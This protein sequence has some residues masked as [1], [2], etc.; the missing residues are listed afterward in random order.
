MIFKVALL[1]YLTDKRY[2]YDINGLRKTKKYGNTTYKYYYSGDKLLVEDTNNYSNR[3][4]YDEKGQLYGFIQNGNKYFYVRDIM[5]NILG[6]SSQSGELVVK[7]NYDAYGKL[8]ST[9]GTLAS[10]VGVQNPFLYKG[11]I[12]DRETELYYCKSRYYNPNIGRWISPDAIEYLNP[13]SINGLNLYCYCNNNPIMYADFDGLTPEW[14]SIT[15]P[16]I[17]SILNLFELL[18]NTVLMP[19]EISLSSAKILARKSGHLYSAR[20]LIK[21]REDDI[22]RTL[23]L[24]KSIS[25]VANIIGGTLFAIDIVSSWYNNYNSGSESWVTDSIVDNAIDGA[26]FLISF[27]PGWGWIASL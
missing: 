26:I 23:K 16:S 5:N 4:L 24:S 13:T 22:A 15:G 11:Y 9:I 20:E 19:K 18:L 14:I 10:T 27:I 8:L 25:K 21:G 2:T 17:E 7:Y 12:Y 6:I 3:F 1:F